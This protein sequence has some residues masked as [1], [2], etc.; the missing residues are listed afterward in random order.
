M[1]VIPEAQ[2]RG[3]G[4]ALLDEI[5][6]TARQM[7]GLEQL[8]LSV[9]EQNTAAK[10]LYLSCGFELYSAE[11]RALKIGAHYLNELHLLRYLDR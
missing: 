1:Y 7:T 6:F 11:P 9:T 3:I 10:S 4:R 2:G 8:H 5:L